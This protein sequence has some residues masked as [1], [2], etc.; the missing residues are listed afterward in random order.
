MNFLYALLVSLALF[1]LSFPLIKVYQLENYR[2]KNFLKNVFK[3]NLSFGDK[4]RLVFTKRLKRMLFCHFFLIFVLFLL[5]F[6][7]IKNVYIEL[8]LIFSGVIL[9]PFLIVLSHFLILPF[10]EF[11][12][13]RYIKKAK[14][15][16]ENMPCKTI[17]I[18]GSFGKTSTKNILLEILARK[19]KV[20]AT[21]KSYNTP[22]GI[23]RTILNDL[24]P[25]DDFFVVEMGAR[26]RGDIA[27]LCDLVGVDY[28]I[29]TPVG[30][31]HI[32]TFKNL[33]N[34]EKT[35]FELC[36]NVKNFVVINGQ[37]ASSM[38]L[39]EKCDKKKYLIGKENSFAYATCERC[40]GGRSTFQLNID[41]KSVSVSTNLL[42]RANIDNIVLAS[43]VAYLLGVNLMDIKSG[44]EKLT[45]VPHRLEL[46]K[47][48]ATIID[49]S[50]N[51]NFDGFCEALSVLNSFAGEKILVTPG[52]VELGEEQEKLNRLVA[53]KI[54]KVCDVVVVMNK[55]NKKALREGLQEAGFNMKNVFYA[56]SRKEQKE[57][58][59]KIVGKNSVILLENDLPDNYR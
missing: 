34:V 24:S 52:M 58:L 20:C 21:P 38:K 17:A 49:D 9:L 33:S 15:K 56:N 19:F 32:E 4:N 43:S 7:L 46:I 18:T 37:S 11:L 36:E 55:V 39:F 16:L 48:F 8:G 1:G 5:I 42:G 26:H 23:C 51:S 6:Y 45:P 13:K 10:E 35:K 14:K 53:K 31:C 25:L 59:K 28:G 50:Y 29:L 44:I 27:F 41:G 2:V 47:G 12:K 3:F 54:A 57:I 40:M 22:M 30:L